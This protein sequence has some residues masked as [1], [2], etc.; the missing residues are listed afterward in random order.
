MNVYAQAANEI[1]RQQ[2]IIIG[3]IAYD[4]ARTVKGLR[5]TDGGDVTIEGDEKQVLASLVESYST[6]FGNASVE[7][8]R[9]AVRDLKPALKPEELPDVLK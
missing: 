2:Q 7:V 6:L 5:F 3:P 9:D 4:Q 1:I 8:C